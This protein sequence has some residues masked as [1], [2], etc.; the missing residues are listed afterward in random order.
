MAEVTEPALNTQF[1]LIRDETQ[2][3]GNTKL[4]VY[5]ALK[6]LYDSLKAAIAGKL[7]NSGNP[8]INGVLE[9]NSD[10]T[11]VPSIYLFSLPL[12]KS[13]R[14]ITAIGHNVRPHPTIAGSFLLKGNGVSNGGYID[15]YCNNYNPYRALIPSTGSGDQV[16]TTPQLEA[17]LVETYGDFASKDIPINTQT[18]SYGIQLADRGGL[19]RMNVASANTLTVPNNSLVPFPVGTQIIITQSGAGQTTVMAGSGVTINSFGARMRLTAQFCGATLIKV[20]PPANDPTN[21]N[22]WLLMGDLAA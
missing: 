14:T 10:G 3:S 13:N 5:D 7:D 9:V 19:V 21:F 2:A 8:K 1:E 4:R 15:V 6:N 16:L 12:L 20:P 17:M 11:P 18:A 22:Y